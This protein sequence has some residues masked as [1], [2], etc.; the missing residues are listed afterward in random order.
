MVSFHKLP[1]AV[2]CVGCQ[3]LPLVIRLP[4]LTMPYRMEKDVASLAELVETFAAKV[5]DFRHSAV[6]QFLSTSQKSADPVSKMT[7]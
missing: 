2:P 5:W 6:V 7:F 4:V 3:Q 1:E